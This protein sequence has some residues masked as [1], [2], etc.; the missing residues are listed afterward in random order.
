MP[1]R[2]LVL[3]LLPYAF[4]TRSRKAAAVLSADHD[5]TFISLSKVGRNKSWDRHGRWDVGGV[6][7]QQVSV[8]TPRTEPTR[9]N[10]LLNVLRCY[11]PGLVRLSTAAFRQPAELAFVNGAYLLPVGILHSIIFKSYLILDINER[12]GMVATKGSVAAVFSRIEKRMLRMSAQFVDTA[13]VATYADVDIVRSLG[14]T[15]VRLLRNVP[16]SEWKADW[17]EP[18]F[19]QTNS[20]DPPSLRAIA[21][22]TM[23][24]GRGYEILIRAVAQA[25]ETTRVDLVLCGPGR[26]SYKERLRQ[27]AE[28][29]GSLERVAFLDRV[30]SAEV[31]CLYLEADVGLVLYEGHDAGNDGLSNKLFECV[32][33]GRPVIASNLPENARFVS[34]SGVGWLVET[35]PGDIA[36]A[37]IGAA[38]R[39]RLASLTEHCRRFG[40]EHLN[41][42]HEFFSAIRSNISPNKR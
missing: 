32:A 24:E 1:D 20:P 36:K 5:T 6:K 16:L 11:L 8:R 25:N 26:D 19:L 28:E 30:E 2:A 42:E 34:E 7:I 35:T 9:L 38:E 23:Y 39:G 31:S 41:W 21:M 27:L 37:L 29:S 13:T 18:P 22:G 15:D 3:S 4:A 17:K 33:S 14:F 10:I 40:D 12:P